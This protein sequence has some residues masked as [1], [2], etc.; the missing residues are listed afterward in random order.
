[1]AMIVVNVVVQVKN[2]GMARVPG[3][4]LIISWPYELES[5]HP[6]GKHILYLLD[7]PLVG[8]LV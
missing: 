4:T 8:R 1:M 3:S 2:I 6:S 5:H 7:P